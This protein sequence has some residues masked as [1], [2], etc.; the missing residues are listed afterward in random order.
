MSVVAD[1]GAALHDAAAQ[2]LGDPELGPATADRLAEVREEIAT[3]GT[4]THTYEELTLGA[5]WAWRNAARCIGRLHW[6]SLRVLDR[7]DC[8]TAEEVAQA[9]FEHIRFSTNDGNLRPDDHAVRAAPARRRADPDLEP[10]THPLRGRAR[11]G[12]FGR[13]RPAERRHHRP[14]DQP[15]LAAARWPV[16]RAAP[17]RPDAGRGAETVRAAAR[18]RWSRSTS[19]TR[20]CRGWPSWACAGTRYRP[21]RTWRWRWAACATRRHRS[22][23]GT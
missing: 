9:C 23:A 15:G 10:A 3:T 13:R 8:A 18:T 7:R 12:R 20:I 16:R 6:R 21:F 22:P 5:L 11:A 14:R 1:H 17:G 2:F 19:S 4:Y